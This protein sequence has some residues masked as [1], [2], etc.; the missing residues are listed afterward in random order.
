MY[1]WKPFVFTEFELCIFLT[2]LILID[3]FGHILTQHVNS[4]RSGQY[5]SDFQKVYK[6]M[7]SLH[8]ISTLRLMFWS[9]QKSFVIGIQLKYLH[10]SQSWI[11][12]T[13]NKS[14]SP[15]KRK[16]T[17]VKHIHTKIVF[18]R[19]SYTPKVTNGKRAYERRNPKMNPNRWA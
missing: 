3:F 4:R 17:E 1:D 5:A 13:Q 19:R 7:Y 12:V 8:Y 15:I 2:L 10:T 11:G 18:R 16:T 9:A 14:R 6:L